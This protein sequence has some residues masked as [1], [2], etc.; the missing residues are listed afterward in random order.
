M[1][2]SRRSEHLLIA[3]GGM[4]C[5]LA[6]FSATWLLASMVRVR[7]TTLLIEG[8]ADKAETRDLVAAVDAKH[9]DSASTL[10]LWFAGIPSMFYITQF[11]GHGR[12]HP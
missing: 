5:T 9:V 10:S 7:R 2:S 6:G 1:I 3:A 11:C 8:S 4:K 12:I